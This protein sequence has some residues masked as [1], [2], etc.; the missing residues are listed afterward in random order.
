MFCGYCGKQN[1]DE[2]RFCPKCG[3]PIELINEASTASKDVDSLSDDDSF[4]EEEFE[5]ETNL[6]E[7]SSYEEYEYDD[8]EDFESTVNNPLG[9]QSE[10]PLQANSNIDNQSSVIGKNKKSDDT[11]LLVIIG[12]VTVSIIIIF[13]S[14]LDIGNKKQHEISSNKNSVS[15]K[16]LNQN[17][18][19]KKSQLKEKSQKVS[20][21][22]IAIGDKTICGDHTIQTMKAMDDSVGFEWE[23]VAITDTQGIRFNSE[24]YQKIET[25]DC[26][27][28]TGDRK[29]DLFLKFWAGGNSPSAYN[30]YV[31]LL[32]DPIK[33]V[34][35]HKFHAM[36]EIADINNDGIKEIKSYFSFRYIGG[37]CGACSPPPINQFLCFQNGRYG[38]CSRQF[39]DYYTEVISYAKKEISIELEKI[40]DSEASADDMELD[41]LKANSVLILA[42]AILLDEEELESEYLRK[43]LPGSVFNWLNEIENRDYID[44]V[45]KSN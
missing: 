13:L 15:R 24:K 29:P 43:T 10:L 1:S 23:Y 12:I 18:L 45:I 42:S 7:G 5:E 17:K 21:V 44:S 31:Y 19:L 11:G 16:N 40:P 35:E 38:D 33:L 22:E 8:N 32:E 34:L 14:D 6:L 30:S 25:V 4:F 20:Q 39:P 26:I 9:Q 3:K 28:L 27:D 41:G 37:L 36:D 2:Y